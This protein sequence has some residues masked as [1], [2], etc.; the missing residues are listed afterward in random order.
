MYVDVLKPYSNRIFLINFPPAS[1]QLSKEAMTVL[2]KFD[3][4]LSVCS[5]S[6]KFTAFVAD[7]HSFFCPS[8][9][10]QFM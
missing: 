5:S 2:I 9:V 4:A 8:L 7:R 6:V 10:L 3:T 1:L